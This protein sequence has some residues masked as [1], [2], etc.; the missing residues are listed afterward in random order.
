LVRRGGR[1]VLPRC[2]LYA[3]YFREHLL[4]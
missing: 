1:M 3:E 2:P 4:G